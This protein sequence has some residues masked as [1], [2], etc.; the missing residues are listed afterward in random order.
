MFLKRALIKRA[1]CVSV[2]F[3]IRMLSSDSKETMSSCNQISVLNLV[4]YIEG[5]TSHCIAPTLLVL[6]LCPSPLMQPKNIGLIAT[7]LNCN[8][9]L[10]DR[11]FGEYP[12]PKDTP[13]NTRSNSQVLIL[14]ICQ[15]A[16]T[17]RRHIICALRGTIDLA[18]WAQEISPVNAR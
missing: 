4:E 17:P 12:G 13:S 10:I 18:G 8:V 7:V 5:K 11:N 14:P 9:R 6:H 16:T 15:S 3:G 1:D 2:G